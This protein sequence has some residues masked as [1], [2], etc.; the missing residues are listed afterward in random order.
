M[1]ELS[2]ALQ[3]ICLDRFGIKR[4]ITQLFFNF[5]GK[6]AVGI[7]DHTG[8]LVQTG[9]TGCFKSNPEHIVSDKGFLEAVLCAL[10]TQAHFFLCIGRKRSIF[11]IKLH[12]VEIVAGQAVVRDIIPAG[13]LH[14]LTHLPAIFTS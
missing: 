4:I 14:T 5:F 2:F 6:R 3:I 12:I 11:T 10:Q 13:T 1:M 7:Q 9:G 8:H